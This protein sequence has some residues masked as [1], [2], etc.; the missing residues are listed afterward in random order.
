MDAYNK[1]MKEKN[2]ALAAAEKCQRKM[3]LATRLVNALGS[4]LDRWS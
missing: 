4:E 2:D 1:A 3:D